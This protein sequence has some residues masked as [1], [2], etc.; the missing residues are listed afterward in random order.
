MRSGDLAS[1]LVLAE[2][3]C[4]KQESLPE[5]V[6]KAVAHSVRGKA[7]LAE[8]KARE[9]LSDLLKADE[10][11]SKTQVW[12]EVAEVSLQLAKAYLRQGKLRFAALHCRTALDTIEHVAGRLQREE[13]RISFLSDPRRAELY[14][15]ANVLRRAAE[16]PKNDFSPADED[17]DRQGTT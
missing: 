12:D 3:A 16:R 4:R 13:H 9:A 5:S 6:A 8:G 15:V 10:F 2:S 14:E 17:D 11:F 1:A 7:L